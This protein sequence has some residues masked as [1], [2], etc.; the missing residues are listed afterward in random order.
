MDDKDQL[1]RDLVPPEIM[2]SVSSLYEQALPMLRAAFPHIAEFEFTQE[3]TEVVVRVHYQ[4][5]ATRVVRLPEVPPTPE[6]LV[7][8]I[9]GQEGLDQTAIDNVRSLLGG[10]K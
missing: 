5:D 4:D 7:D 8:A 10:D 1:L 9:R 3:G 2:G 6:A